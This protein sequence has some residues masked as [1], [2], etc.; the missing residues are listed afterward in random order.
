MDEA[1]NPRR[2]SLHQ[3][4]Q[5]SR[6]A[7]FHITG[8]DL[9]NARLVAA[10]LAFFG[11]WSY[12]PEGATPLKSESKGGQAAAS[13]SGKNGRKEV[14]GELPPDEKTLGPSWPA[15]DFQTTRNDK[16]QDMKCLDIPGWRTR[17]LIVCVPDPLD[18]SS[19]YCFDYLIDVIQRA[20][21]TQHFVLDRYYYPWPHKKLA[22][23]SPMLAP[24]AVG[25]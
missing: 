2:P 4:P 24:F 22:N 21:E 19:D 20:A 8:L 3:I 14:G 16:D 12:S 25:V 7:K 13:E 1:S 18:S 15:L 9:R 5:G 6:N 23:A 10:L 11:I 17:Y